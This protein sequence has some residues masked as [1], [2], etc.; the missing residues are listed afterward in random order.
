MHINGESGTLAS[1]HIRQKIVEGKLIVPDSD[2]ELTESGVFSSKRLESRVQPASFEPTAS[3]HIFVIDSENSAFTPEGKRVSDMLLKMPGQRARKVSI[4]NGYELKRGYTYLIPLNEK[5][6][7]EKDEYVKSSPKSSI[8]RLFLD[9]RMVSDFSRSYDIIPRSTTGDPVSIY[10][11]VQPLAFNVILRPM[12]VLNQLR[13]F[14]GLDCELSNSEI[15]KSLNDNPEKNLI[16]YKNK[17]DTASLSKAFHEGLYLHY[18]LEPDSVGFVAYR[19]LKNPDP[20]DLSKPAG[21]YPRSAY[22][23]G[24]KDS[25]DLRFIPGENYIMRTA[26]LL[27]IPPELNAELEFESVSAVRGPKHYAGFIDPSFTGD[28]VAEFT[29]AEKHLLKLSHGLILSRLKFYRMLA[30]P[31]KLYGGRI[32]SHYQNQEG[33]KVAKYFFEDCKKIEEAPRLGQ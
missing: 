4:I 22:F 20:I 10:L 30:M 3:D 32:G 12:Q 33:A 24:L 15:S 11:L 5:I 19:A 1:Q 26:E 13:F 23:E 2:K 9:L 17:S 21:S 27:S 16:Q 31:D 14:R 6:I 18:G 28:L 7:L 25:D 29:P 8:G